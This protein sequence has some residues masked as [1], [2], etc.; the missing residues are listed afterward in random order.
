MERAALDKE[1]VWTKLAFS[2]AALPAAT[3][4]APQHWLQSPAQWGGGPPAL[5]AACLPQ[6]QWR[7][8]AATAPL[9]TC[10]EASPQITLPPL[11]PQAETTL[12]GAP[13]PPRKPSRLP[14]PGALPL[15][16]HRLW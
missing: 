10:P 14:G 6:G 7:D 5:P 11:R 15:Q 1:W 3:P 4:L 9:P 2:P 13:I 8:G 12:W 16:P